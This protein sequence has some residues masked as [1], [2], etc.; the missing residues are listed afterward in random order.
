MGILPVL[1]SVTFT[2]YQLSVGIIFP[3]F[4]VLSPAKA[5][6]RVG[7][8]P[9][10]VIGFLTMELSWIHLLLH[11][12][13]STSLD[14]IDPIPAMIMTRLYLGRLFMAMHLGNFLY[15]F[16]TRSLAQNA[17]VSF[18]SKVAVR[19]PEKVIKRITAPSVL[20][21]SVFLNSISHLYLYHHNV[22]CINDITYVTKE[23]LAE[24][25][26]TKS[27]HFLQLDVIRHSTKYKSRPILLYIHGGAWIFGDKRSHFKAGR[28]MPIC[29]YFAS[30]AH[31]VVINVNYRLADRA[32]LFDM[33]LDLKR[34]IRWIK[35]NAHIHGGDPDF[36]TVS[37]GSAGGHLAA[38]IALTANEKVFQPGLEFL[39]CI[40]Y[41]S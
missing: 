5:I 22:T 38:L 1:S 23:E 29:W 28:T 32:N 3:V 37:G 12:V 36:I 24:A 18:S 35:Q 10:S 7:H 6:R 27:V 40:L 17:A 9:A 13:L 25:G 41:E 11:W 16:S 15:G 19:G 20:N 2:I 31:Y 8:W 21:P 33:L 34:C 4:S 26:G 30:V 39:S 14:K